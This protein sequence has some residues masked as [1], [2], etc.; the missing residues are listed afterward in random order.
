[1]HRCPIFKIPANYSDNNSIQ[2]VNVTILCIKMFTS[3]QCRKG[4]P[5][6]HHLHS[7]LEAVGSKPLIYSVVN[8]HMGQQSQ[9]RAHR[10][11][12][13]IKTNVPKQEMCP[14]NTATSNGNISERQVSIQRQPCHFFGVYPKKLNKL[15]VTCK[16]ELFWSRK[17]C[18][19]P[20]SPRKAAI[21]PQRHVM[22]TPFFMCSLW[23]DLIWSGRSRVEISRTR[24]LNSFTCPKCFKRARPNVMLSV[25]DK[26]S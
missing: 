6:L 25:F 23:Q 3:L 13:K 14:I 10:A 15:W 5:P 2:Y 24:C 20:W 12:Q 21:F 19:H 8:K 4:I 1:M 17:K 26:E 11:A 16:D 18:R 22:K 9:I 7:R